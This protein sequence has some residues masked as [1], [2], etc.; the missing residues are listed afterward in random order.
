[1]AHP[2]GNQFRADKVQKSR[3]SHIARGY[4][5]GGGVH[6]DE[7]EDRK[8]IRK[9]VKKSALRADGGSVKARADKVS[10][11]KGGRVRSKGAKTNVNVIIAPSGQK[12]PMAGLGPM[13]PAPPMAAAPPMPPKP[14]MMPPSPGAMGPVPGVGGMPPMPPR[15]DG[16]RA[17]KK[18]GAVKQKMSG[19]K[20]HGKKPFKMKADGGSVPMP[21]PRPGGKEPDA[22]DLYSPKDR[23]RM[24]KQRWA[25]GAVSDSSKGGTK[26][27]HSGNKSD[28]QNIGRGPVI[29]RATGG[30]IYANG[31]KGKQM[32]WLKGKG[33][34]GGKGR[35]A[36]A[37]HDKAAGH[38]PWLKDAAS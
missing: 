17:Y 14:P 28:A 33:A 30:P 29:T 23:S 19:E 27:Q 20:K 38:E 21:K 37:H 35:L 32:A 13:P 8:L 6:S 10:R 12:P 1:M 25:G 7:A 2:A 9:E 34:G 26:V 5:S 22:D 11:A 18:G 15:S 31:A 16:G 3:V 4:A 36:K 24:E